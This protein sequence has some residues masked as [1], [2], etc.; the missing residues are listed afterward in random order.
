MPSA[1]PPPGLDARVTALRAVAE[2]AGRLTLT[3]FQHPELV[4]E[5]KDDQSPVTVADRA[6]ET[7]IR[8]AIAAD[9]PQDGLL[10]EEHGPAPGT[11]G[12]TWIIDPIDGT[13]SFAHGVPLYGV[14]LALEHGTGEDRRVV[15]GVCELPALGER[16][17]AAA[18][19]GAWWERNGEPVVRARVARADRLSNALIATTGYEYF[20][21]AGT[22][23]ALDALSAQ[24]GRIRGW[25]D[26]YCMALV[27]TGRC[28][29]AVEPWMNP[30][31]SGPFPII[32]EEAGGVFSAW[33]GTPGI[34]CRTAV[35]ANPALHA[36]LV[37][38]L[39]GTVHP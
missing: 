39:R 21:R 7:L 24:A 28:D 13:V 1:A 32:M 17:W 2:R 37:A 20:R 10:G 23:A 22:I 29:G 18:G 9:F 25:T 31:D 36:E 3:Y 26:C 4:V 15:A 33:D 19:R 14:L 34:H 27:A 8:K 35:A 12:Y 38:L 16:V 6:C 30:W 5:Q 11:S